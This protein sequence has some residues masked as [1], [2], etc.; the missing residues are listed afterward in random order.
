MSTAEERE[1]ARVRL[2]KRLDAGKTQAERNRLGQFSTPGKLAKEIVRCAAAL[3][4]PR[5]KIRFLEPGFGTG[6]FS[7]ALLRVVRPSR[8]ETMVGYEIDPYYA[9]PA[10][11]L[12]RGGRL[13]LRS[14]DFTEARPPQTED[15]KFNLL[16]CNPPYVRHHHLSQTQK[17]RLQAS[18]Y[19]HVRLRMNG[20]SGLYTYFVALSKAWMTRNGIGAWLIPSEFMDVNYGRI[21]KD[22][23]TQDV[24]L[25]RIHRFD[26]NDVQ[27]GD[28]LVSSAVLFLQNSPPLKN[29]KVR[30]SVGATIATPRSARDIS[31][32][33]LQQV[34]KWT[35]L[36]ENGPV[37]RDK[38]GAT[39]GDLFSIK[40]GIAT[41][42][43]KFFILPE[44]Q[45]AAK[46]LPQALFTPILPSP[47]DLDTN[48]LMADLQGNP[49]IRKRLFLLVCDLPEEEIRDKYPPLFRYLQQ[50]IEQAI[51]ERY[52]SRHREPW[53]SQETRPPAP[54]LCTYM[55]RATA[56]NSVPF[57]FILNHSKATATNVYLMLYP[58]PALAKVLK[59]SPKVAR[60]VWKALCSL[61]KETLTNEG[62]IYGG[63]LHKLE[64]RE[65]ANVTAEPVLQALKHSTD[66]TAKK[67]LQL[68]EQVTAG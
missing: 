46:H 28:A 53:Y 59:D 35:G 66:F 29:H 8:I 4:P 3:L 19:R 9:D 60:P 30:F 1:A 62:R 25:H 44:E 31:T 16:I 65:L 23:L 67:Q 41:G 37:V 34:R 39:L 5:S 54:F 27:F 7:S 24:T 48:E 47:R 21:L 13:R 36:A 52:L 58:K 42:C 49:R 2:L 14:A 61:K 55:G 20:L 22:F 11:K 15:R 63:G 57:R 51:H 45:I 26:T 17:V 12:W 56:K 6:P 38:A 33:D 43:N 10:R 32:R 18:V 64:P 40:R 50:G 68:F